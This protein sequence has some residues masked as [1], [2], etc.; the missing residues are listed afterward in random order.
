L[1]NSLNLILQEE[2]SALALQDATAELK[3]N[4]LAEKTKI[5]TAAPSKLANLPVRQAN[6]VTELLAKKL[7]LKDVLCLLKE[8]ALPDLLLMELN[9][10]NASKL[11]LKNVTNLKLQLAEELFVLIDGENAVKLLDSWLV[12]L[13]PELENANACLLLVLDVL[14]NLKREEKESLNVSHANSKLNTYVKN[15]LALKKPPVNVKFLTAANLLV[16]KKLNYFATNNHPESAMN[17]NLKF[18]VKEKSKNTA[19][20][21]K[22]SNATLMMNVLLTLKSTVKLQ[23][24][25]LTH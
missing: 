14:K 19:K 13:S 17:L 8:F 20:I 6:V 7:D 21:S 1:E 5:A 16:L 12:V 4:Q 23:T 11:K 15:S 25:S 2:E 22:S 9:V 3:L 10:K 18:A 24:A